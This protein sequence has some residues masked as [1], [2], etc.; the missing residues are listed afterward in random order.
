MIFFGTSLHEL[1]MRIAAMAAIGIYANS[2]IAIR[3]IIKTTIEL[4]N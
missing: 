2:G 4:I 3:T 1:V